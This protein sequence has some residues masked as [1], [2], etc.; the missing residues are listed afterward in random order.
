MKL[1]TIKIVKMIPDDERDKRNRSV[2]PDLTTYGTVNYVTCV[3]HVRQDSRITI[4]HELI[5]W[6]AYQI[7]G[8]SHWLHAWLDRKPIPRPWVTYK[9]R[10]EHE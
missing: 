10:K 5:H 3:I 9:S 2:Q 7:G 8:T 1:P 6:F 4:I